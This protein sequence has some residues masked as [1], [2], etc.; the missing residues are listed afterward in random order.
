MRNLGYIIAGL[1]FTFGLTANIYWIQHQKLSQ[2]PALLWML[3]VE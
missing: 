3:G 1:L 2:M